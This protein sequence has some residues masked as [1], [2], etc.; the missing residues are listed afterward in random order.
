[1][2]DSEAGIRAVLVAHAAIRLWRFAI[3]GLGTLV[4]IAR[5]ANAM[6]SRRAAGLPRGFCADASHADNLRKLLKR[7]RL[8]SHLHTG[9][10]PVGRRFSP[11]DQRSLSVL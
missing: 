3:H 7:R 6:R 4:V 5:L 1:M 10:D 11:P 9:R 2:Y 8:P